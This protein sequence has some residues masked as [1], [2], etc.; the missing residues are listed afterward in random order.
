MSP[1]EL[2][3]RCVWHSKDARHQASDAA[4]QRVYHIK[5]AG[6]NR[7]P[8][9]VFTCSLHSQRAQSPSSKSPIPS[10]GC[11]KEAIINNCSDDPLSSISGSSLHPVVAECA[12]QSPSSVSTTGTIST[13]RAVEDGN[14]N[15]KSSSS[16]ATFDLVDFV[17]NSK[18][19]F[20]VKATAAAHGRVGYLGR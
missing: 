2:C 20:R 3:V 18:L 7:V 11:I 1:L 6:L 9:G 10:A 19:N 8:K 14:S 12:Q 13:V 5:C 17:S 4:L 16:P 15:C